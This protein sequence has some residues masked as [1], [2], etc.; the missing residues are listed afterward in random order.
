MLT[1]LWAIFVQFQMSSTGSPY[2]E[3]EEKRD[4]HGLEPSGR[5]SWRKG[6][7]AFEGGGR[8]VALA[9]NPPLGTFLVPGGIAPLD[10][11]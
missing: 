4:L 6:E 2:S 11:V 9:R 7:T 3:E 5:A 10:Q 1:S 8:E